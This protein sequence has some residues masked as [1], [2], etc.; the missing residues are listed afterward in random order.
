MATNNQRHGQTDR[1]TDGQL[2]IAI[3]RAL[4]GKNSNDDT[5]Q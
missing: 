4:H 3:L 2:T 5:A 1:K